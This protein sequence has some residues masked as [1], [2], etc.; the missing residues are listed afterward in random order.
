MARAMRGVFTIPSTPFDAQGQIDEQGLRSVIDFCIEC[1]AHGLVWPVNASNFPTMSD[2]ERLWGAQVAVEQAAGRLPVIIGSAGVSAPHAAMFAAHAN[3]IGA[4]GVIAMCPYVKKLADADTIVAYYQAINAVVDIPI[5]IQNHG[6]GSELSVDLMTRLI[7]EVEHIEYIKEETMPATHKLTQL[8]ELGLPK[9]KGVFGGSGGRYLLLEHPRGSAGQMPGCHVTDVM[10]QLWNALEDGDMVR[11][12][13]VYGAM[14][15][16]HALEVQCQGAIYPEVLRR[17][18]VIAG[19]WQRNAP[20]GRM[21]AHDHQAL[22]DILRDLEPY[23]T[24]DGPSGA[25]AGA[26]PEASYGVESVGGSDGS[27]DP[28]DR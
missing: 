15:P 5:F 13:A 4:D 24:W 11:A 6:V 27:L 12:K 17:R 14:A 28:F 19:A 9:L 16:L 10:V 7:R 26:P 2:Q 8:V 18:G 25:D 21:D 20:A 3:S 23:M 1:G 22:N